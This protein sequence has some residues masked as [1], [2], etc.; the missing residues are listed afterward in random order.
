MNS[1]WRQ[2][3]SS[4]IFEGD[5]LDQ[6]TI[7]AYDTRA[8]DFAAD[9][10]DHQAAPDDLRD[11]VRQFFLAGPTADIGCGSGRDTAWLA[12]NAFD[13]VGVDASKGLI[14]EAKRRHCGIRF[15]VG[16]LPELKMLQR[17]FYAN[18]LCETVI[19]HLDVHLIPEAVRQLMSLLAPGGILYLTWRVTKDG[20][21][22]D[23]MGR[24]YSSFAAS[25]VL[26]RLAQSKIMLNEERVSASSGKA[27]HRIVACK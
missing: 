12:E 10:E 27:I 24:L 17:D 3:R 25:L 4:E 9:W 15:E 26:D 20:D 2:T 11:A 19:M 21:M 1:Q 23:D 16:Q 14:K 18:V 5:P 13:V 8:V 7:R 6:K 22:R